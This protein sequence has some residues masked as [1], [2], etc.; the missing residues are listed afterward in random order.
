MLIRI[1]TPETLI[2]L[3]SL[4]LEERFG[5]QIHATY[6][7]HQLPHVG[8][9]L[10]SVVFV[11]R[12]GRDM[13]LLHFIWYLKREHDLRA[14]V[15]NSLYQAGSSSCYRGFYEVFLAVLLI[16]AGCTQGAQSF[17]VPHNHPIDLHSRDSLIVCVRKDKPSDNTLPPSLPISFPSLAKWTHTSCMKGRPRQANKENLYPSSREARSFHGSGSL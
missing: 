16:I 17:N 10:H 15:K 9:T 1:V 13:G 7:S 5:T 11:Q 4:T 3:A 6:A 2:W 14:T 8:F 12:R